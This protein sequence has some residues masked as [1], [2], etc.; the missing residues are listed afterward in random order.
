MSEK[1]KR[2]QKYNEVIKLLLRITLLLMSAQILLIIMTHN[3]IVNILREP[4]HVLNAAKKVEIASFILRKETKELAGN[5]IMVQKDI[6][7]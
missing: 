7:K 2:D 6:K 1:G 3:R 5:V 4:I